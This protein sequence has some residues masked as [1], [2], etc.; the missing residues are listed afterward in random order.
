MPLDPDLL[1]RLKSALDG[2]EVVYTLSDNK[3][4]W[5]HGVE[6]R[7]VLVETERSRSRGS[8]PQLVPAKMLQQAWDLLRAN[9]R[10]SQ[11]VLLHELEMRRSAAVFAILATLPEV[12]VESTRPDTTLRL[13][14]RQH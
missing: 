1:G 7:G 11:R 9:G 12:E 10:I 3:P 8:G 14:A 4:N 13:S 5:I 2:R 6:E